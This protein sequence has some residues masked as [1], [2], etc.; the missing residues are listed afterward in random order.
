MSS[1][2]LQLWYTRC[3][4]P[5]ATS[6]AVELGWLDDEFA[7]DGIP[8]QSLASSDDPAVHQAHFAQTI[9]GFFRQGG[10]LPP[11]V[12]RARGENVRLIGVSWPQTTHRILVRSGSGITDLAD[13]AGQRLAVPRRT[14]DAIDFWNVTV[15]RAWQQALSSARL[16]DADVQLVDFPVSRKFIDTATSGAGRRASLWGAE[17]SLRF[18]SE[19]ALALARGDVDAIF[20]EGGTAV[21]LRHALNLS[22]LKDLHEYPDVSGRVN[23]GYPLAL[24]V[25]GDLLDRRPDVVARWVSRL[26]DAAH[27]AAENERETKRILAAEAGIAEELVDEAFGADAHRELSIETAESARAAIESQNRRLVDWGVIDEPVDLDS[28]IVS[29]DLIETAVAA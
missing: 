21:V 3:P 7:G 5:T 12:A 28:Y 4:V 27:W 1:D 29:H 6:L 15:R 9:P 22:I 2:P 19:E 14:D 17:S 16:A 26:Q 13:L 8:V 10:N 24:T 18:Q 11:L 20:S 23:N 25:T